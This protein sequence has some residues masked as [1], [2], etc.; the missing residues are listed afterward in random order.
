[1]LG[2]GGF[3][4]AFLGL[5]GVWHP[6]LGPTVAVVAGVLGVVFGA[7][8]RTWGTAALV[9]ALFACAAGA[10]VAALKHAFIPVAAVAASLGLFLGVT[11]QRKLEL[12]LP[13]VFAALFAALGAAIGWGPHWRGASLYWLNDVE[14]VLALFGALLPP[15][16][17]LAFQRDRWRREKLEGR[18]KEMDDEDLKAALAARQAEVER[19]ATATA[20][21]EEP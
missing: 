20:A 15:L 21:E 7:V 4:A 9:A 1:M 13:P 17:I 19:A 5:R 14:W 18:T 6:W 2:I 3:A 12:Y 16:V 11:R 8:A 10:A